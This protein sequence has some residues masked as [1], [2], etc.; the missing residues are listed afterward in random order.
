[1]QIADL[2]EQ[3]NAVLEQA[4]TLLVQDFNEPRG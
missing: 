2:G 1:M 3:P 4:A